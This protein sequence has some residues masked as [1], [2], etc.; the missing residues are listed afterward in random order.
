MSATSAALDQEDSSS[1]SHGCSSQPELH[2]PTELPMA[3]LSESL[4]LLS[5]TGSSHSITR[6]K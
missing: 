2:L 1:G 5:V 3:S 6:G 4:L